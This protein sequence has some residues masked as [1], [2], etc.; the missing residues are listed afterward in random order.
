MTLSPPRWT[1]EQF[2]QGVEKGI[3]VFRHDRLNEARADYSSHFSEA[4]HAIEHVL[5]LSDDLRK[6]S[7]TGGYLEALRYVADRSGRCYSRCLPRT[8]LAFRSD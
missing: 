3:E 4:R 2:Q 7:Q 1:P 6:I 5:E 8:K